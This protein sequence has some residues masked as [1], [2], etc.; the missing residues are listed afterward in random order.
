MQQKSS[1]EFDRQKILNIF[2]IT[3]VHYPL[4]RHTIRPFPDLHTVISHL[5][6]IHFN[7]TLQSTRSFQ[8]QVRK[9]AVLRKAY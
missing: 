5:S 6:K 3:K 7:R 2:K 1:G 4:Q 9:K 8:E